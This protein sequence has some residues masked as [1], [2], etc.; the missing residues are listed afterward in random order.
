MD[1]K[2]ED[3]SV[4]ILGFRGNLLVDSLKKNNIRNYKLLEDESDISN[5]LDFVFVSGYYKITRIFFYFAI[6]ITDN[7]FSRFNC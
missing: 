3:C 5:N 1:K 2:F 7:R 6:R 4:G